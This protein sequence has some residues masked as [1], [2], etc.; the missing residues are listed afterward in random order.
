M[1]PKKKIITGYVSSLIEQ[2]LKQWNIK[3]EEYVEQK[4]Q[5]SG[6]PYYLSIDQINKLL[7][8]ADGIES[9]RLFVN[10]Y[11]C[12]VQAGFVVK[13]IYYIFHLTKNLIELNSLFNAIIKLK[14][15]DFLSMQ[16]VTSLCWIF[17]DISIGYTIE[18]FVK[19]C[20][21]LR[22]EYGFKVNDIF[23]L[24]FK[25]KIEK[26]KEILIYCNHFFN[27]G[28]HASQIL[29]LLLNKQLNFNWEC[30]MRYSARFKALSC[31]VNDII[32]LILFSDHSEENISL[33]LEQ[34]PHFSEKQPSH[35]SIMNIVFKGAS[36][37]QGLEKT[38]GFFF[39]EVKRSS[40]EGEEIEIQYGTIIRSNLKYPEFF[41]K[42]PRAQAD[43]NHSPKRT[44]IA[45]EELPSLFQLRDLFIKN[46]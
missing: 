23:L 3:S 24:I 34:Y 43:E 4:R 44:C 40:G 10:Y 5:L 30:F 13:D 41:R 14:D 6:H 42:R 38:T 15:L 18:D 8:Q 25:Y 20:S 46:P 35:Q 21:S 37:H 1:P 27:L 22:L 29:N 11:Q 33:F 12:L 16:I 39:E 7:F 17:S 26:F 19:H 9:A 36:I 28:I 2:A 45:G 32:E 31:S